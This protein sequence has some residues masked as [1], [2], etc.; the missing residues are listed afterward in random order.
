MSPLIASVKINSFVMKSDV[1]VVAWNVLVKF[2]FNTYWPLRLHSIIYFRYSSNRTPSKLIHLRPIKHVT[3]NGVV[4]G[5]DAKWRHRQQ[6][7]HRQHHSHENF[8]YDLKQSVKLSK[9]WYIINT[10]II[11]KRDYYTCMYLSLTQC[12]TERTSFKQR[13]CMLPA[14]HE[15][16][17]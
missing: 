10:N 14:V 7:Q 13:L 3:Q 5:Y 12:C 6:K 4:L 1:W 16:K 15:H 2:H 11:T 9:I 17:A 8:K